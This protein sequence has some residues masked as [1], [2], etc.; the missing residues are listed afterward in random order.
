MKHCMPKYSIVWTADN[1]RG[2]IHLHFF[3][4]SPLESRVYLLWR[5]A[6]VVSSICCR[7]LTQLLKKL[8][9][10]CK[11]EELSQVQIFS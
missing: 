4:V 2:A 3:S 6:V 11:F 8:Q 9:K 1:Y 7:I 10:K 5:S